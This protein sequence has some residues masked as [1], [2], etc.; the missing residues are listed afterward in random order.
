MRHTISNMMVGLFLTLPAMAS[1]GDY[2]LTPEDE[3]KECLQDAREPGYEFVRQV[4]YISTCFAGGDVFNVDIFKVAKCRGQRCDTVR[5]AAEHIA[6]AYYVCDELVDAECLIY[7][8]CPKIYA[9]VC[10]DDGVTYGNAC[11]ADRVG[12]SYTDG[13]CHNGVCPDIWLPVCGSDGVTYGNSCEAEFA[14]VRYTDGAC[15]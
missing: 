12:V 2:L 14:G 8:A 7:D 1:A 3:I 13:E 15:E 9:P 11:E 10:G 5:L 6:T 4:S